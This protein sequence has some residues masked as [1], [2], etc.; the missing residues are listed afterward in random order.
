MRL[1]YSNLITLVV[2]IME[3]NNLI[4]LSIYCET[5]S[6]SLNIDC[7]VLIIELSK[8]SVILNFAQVSHLSPLAWPDPAHRDST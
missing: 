8:E 2:Q 3:R 1:K 7:C 4:T 6:V 5:T